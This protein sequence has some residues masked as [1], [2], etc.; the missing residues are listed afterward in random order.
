[1]RVYWILL[2]L[3]STA[4]QPSQASHENHPSGARSSGMAHASVML[5]DFWSFHHN[6]AGLPFLKRM[7]LGF[8]HQSGFVREMNHQALALVIPAD[9][10]AIAGS[11]PITVMSITTK[12][13]P[14]LLMAVT[15]QRI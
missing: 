1:M 9:R 10:S 6:Q 14:P 3:L 5:P 7:A 4:T 2:T 15:W 13:R 11:F 12:A 8:Y